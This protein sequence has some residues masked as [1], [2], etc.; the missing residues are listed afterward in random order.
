MDDNEIE[1]LYARQIQEELL[2][3]TGQ[4][5][6]RLIDLCPREFGL[7]NLIP[8]DAGYLA[9]IPEKLAQLYREVTEFCAKNSIEFD[10]TWVITCSCSAP[11]FPFPHV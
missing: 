5:V 6:A 8:S 11:R 9:T 4:A 7:E 2:Q 10:H 3:Q 1:Q